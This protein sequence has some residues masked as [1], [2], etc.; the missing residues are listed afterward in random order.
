MEMKNA[1][2]HVWNLFALE[3]QRILNEHGMGLGHLDD[4]MGI[5]REKVRRLKQSL[6]TPP[7]LPLLNPEETQVIID[8][9]QLDSEDTLRLYA[10]VLTTSIQRT[11]SDRIHQDDARRAAEQILPTIVQ[12]LRAHVGKKGLGNVRAGDIDPMGSDLDG[13]LDIILNAMD[14]GSEALQ[15][16]YYVRTATEGVKKARQAHNYYKEALEDLE[17][18]SRSIRRQPGWQSWYREAQSGLNMALSRLDELGG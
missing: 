16:S 7:G 17:S 10:A 1:T 18:L 8:T 13:A 3:L 6:Y 15:L 2:G 11:L 12:S 14:R 9:L 4:R 5:H